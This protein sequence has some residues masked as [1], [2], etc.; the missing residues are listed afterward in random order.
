[1]SRFFTRDDAFAAIST[2]RAA[3]ASMAGQQIVRG[4]ESA[5]GNHADADAERLGGQTP[6]FPFLL[7]RARLRSSEM[8]ASA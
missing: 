6:T 1:M 2:A 5:I 4:S 3:V 7:E 8:R